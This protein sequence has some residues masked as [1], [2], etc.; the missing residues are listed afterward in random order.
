MIVEKMRHVAALASEE[1]ANAKHVVAR[2]QESFAERRAEEAR[3][4][5]ARTR[6]CSN[7]V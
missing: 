4:T 7:I 3:A 1:V 2:F 5:S 6:L